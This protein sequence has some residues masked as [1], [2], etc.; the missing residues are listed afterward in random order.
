MLSAYKL[1]ENLVYGIVHG[2]KNT[3]TFCRHV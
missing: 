2:E 3:I 1:D